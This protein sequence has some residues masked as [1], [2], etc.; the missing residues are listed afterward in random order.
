[1][2]IGGIANICSSAPDSDA[3]SDD[4]SES[5]PGLVQSPPVAS[6][7]IPGLELTTGKGRLVFGP[8]LSIQDRDAG[9][10][11]QAGWGML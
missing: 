1:M 11:P 9:Y 3:D 4:D 10:L 2:P 7:T 8:S 5:V 6:S